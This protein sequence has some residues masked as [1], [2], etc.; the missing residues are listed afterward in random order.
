MII[1]YYWSGPFTNMINSR[2]IEMGYSDEG[3]CDTV[4]KNKE[5]LAHYNIT[6]C[7]DSPTASNNDTPK[8][9]CISEIINSYQNE[10]VM[11][12]SFRWFVLI[13]ALALLPIAC[14]CWFAKG[15]CHHEW[16][17]KCMVSIVVVWL[18]YCFVWLFDRFGWIQVW[19]LIIISSKFCIIFVRNNL[20][21]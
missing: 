20:Q 3:F 16:P 15:G 18:V 13:W 2:A 19:F 6:C 11:A 21:Y 17:H 10:T 8:A 14:L 4:S 1:F 5:M 12:K 9:Q 7:N